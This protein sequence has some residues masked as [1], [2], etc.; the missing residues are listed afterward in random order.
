MPWLFWLLCIYYSFS[1]VLYFY[2]KY[3]TIKCQDIINLKFKKRR[4]ILVKVARFS[5]YTAES[6]VC[7]IFRI[8]TALTSWYIAISTPLRYQSLPLLLQNVFASRSNHSTLHS[9]GLTLEF[10]STDKNQIA[11][12]FSCE[13]RGMSF[14]LS[15]KQ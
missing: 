11:Y 2:Y 15:C 13:L 8:I 9:K 4:P 10:Y 7:V 3:F 1:Y 14:H 5:Q 12:Q 6:W